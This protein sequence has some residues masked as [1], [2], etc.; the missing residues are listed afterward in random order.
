MSLRA[1]VEIDIFSGRPNPSGLL[2]VEQTDWLLEALN[3][4]PTTDKSPFDGLGYRGLVV[5]LPR[6][7]RIGHGTITDEAFDSVFIDTNRYIEH[8][9]AEW[10]TAF[11]EPAMAAWLMTQQEK[12]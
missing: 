6:Q 4:L 7:L 3:N 11:L 9:L 5:R 2:T 1:T 8:Q 12:E 10:V